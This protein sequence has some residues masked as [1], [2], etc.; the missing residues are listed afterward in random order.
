MKPRQRLW[1]LYALLLA[2]ALAACSQTPTGPSAPPRLVVFMVVD[3]L[4]QRQV[5]DYRQQ[6]APDGLARFLDRGAWFSNAHYGYAY[7]VTAAGHASML[8]GTYAYRHGII[9]NDW[10]N[11]ETGE[12]EYCTG[13]ARY[14]YIGNPTGKLDGT[15]PNN[16]LVETVGDVLKRSN[17]RSKVIGI[18]GKDR[19]AILPAGKT[20][21]AYM[22]MSKSGQFASST[23]YMKEHPAWVDAFNAAKP[24]DRHFKQAWQPVLEGDAYRQSLADEQPWFLIKGAKLPMTMGAAQEKPDGAYYG[25]LLRSPFVD[26]MALEFARAAIKGEALGQDDAPDILAVSLSGH[27]YV[28][29]AFSAESRLSHDHLL[30]LDRLFQAFFEDLDALVGKDNYVTVLTADHGFMPAPETS[31]AAGRHA[32]RQSASQTLT[33]VNAGLAQK[34]GAGTWARFFSASA[35]VLDHKL[36]DERKVDRLAVQEEARALLLKEEGVAVVYTRDELAGNTRAGAPLFDQMRKS[37]NAQRSGD[38]QVALEP[39][40]MFTSSSSTTTHGSP[41]AYDTNVP[42][43]FYGPRWVKRGMVSERVEVSGVA[44]TLAGMLQIP[45]PATSEGKVLPIVVG[46]AH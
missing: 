42:I 27:D 11:F 25:A 24:A 9:G 16:L 3:G 33:R 13:D 2:C 46:D 30:H 43:L 45:P 14:H 5:V 1:S 8:T 18:S 19:G 21:L 36:I 12:L 20:G 28:N 7:T 35:L 40:W 31:L 17:A 29:H 10:R 23:F 37:W 6:L 44:P 38:L 15:S 41:H 32:G 34:F 39:Y 4:P 22:Y 26:E